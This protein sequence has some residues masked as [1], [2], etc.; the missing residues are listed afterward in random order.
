V[1]ATL[2]PTSLLLRRCRL[3]ILVEQ[4]EFALIGI[5]AILALLESV[6]LSGPSNVVE[7][8]SGGLEGN[9]EFPG[10]L[11]GDLA[12]KKQKRAS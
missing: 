1:T 10:L 9:G 2:S 7:G 11:P 3:G 12:D 8:F 4:G 6:P 5:L